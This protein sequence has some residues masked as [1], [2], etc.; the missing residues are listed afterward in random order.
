ML[1][2]PTSPPSANAYTLTYPHPHANTRSL[3]HTHTR[4][5]T[6]GG[7]PSTLSST[8]DIFPGPSQGTPTGGAHDSGGSGAWA[9]IDSIGVNLEHHHQQ[10]QQQHL[11]LD[12]MHA[13]SVDGNT[14]ALGI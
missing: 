11:D 8:S 10:Q 4:T 6:G 14:F 2:P 7:Q 9:G 3:T 1:S 13:L 12:S 5:L